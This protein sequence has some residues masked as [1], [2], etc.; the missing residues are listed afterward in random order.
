M[1][2][3]MHTAPSI[4]GAK[5]IAD[6]VKE[7]LE[8]QWRGWQHLSTM[9][10]WTSISTPSTKRSS[11][12]ATPTMIESRTDKHFEQWQL[13]PARILG[14]KRSSRWRRRCA[15]A[16]RQSPHGSFSTVPR[17][18]LRRP[19][20]RYVSCWRASEMCRDA[21]FGIS[22]DLTSAITNINILEQ[23]SCVHVLQYILHTRTH[24]HTHT[25]VSHVHVSV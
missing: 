8:V 14:I 17:L 18:H 13:L 19:G 5:W 3:W 22:I 16:R 20:L 24:T 25:F 15:M 11:V 9:L 21:F 2:A 12:M 4:K 1:A 7:H 6:A 10:T 23:S